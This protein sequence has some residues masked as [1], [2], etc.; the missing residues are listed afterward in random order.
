MVLA[1]L[2]GR[3]DFHFPSKHVVIYIGFAIPAFT[4]DYG[5]R[6]VDLLVSPVVE[7]SCGFVAE[8]I[9]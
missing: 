3:P 6:N 5:V 8:E 9:G 7:R 1:P 2:L 4:A